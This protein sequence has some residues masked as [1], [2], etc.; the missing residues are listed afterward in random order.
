MAHLG[1]AGLVIVIVPAQP[2]PDHHLRLEERMTLLL[3]IV[4]VTAQPSPDHQ[5]PEARMMLLGLS[6]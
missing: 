4:V 6:L 5:R 3:L 1:W 2:S